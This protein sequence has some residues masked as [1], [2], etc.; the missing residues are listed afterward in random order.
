MI[1]QCAWCHRLLGQKAPIEDRSIT[2]GICVSCSQKLLA[3]VTV[4]AN[5]NSSPT[6]NKRCHARTD[7]LT[8]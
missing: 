8:K 3:A 2:H 4:G 7:A 1:C 5:T 6:E